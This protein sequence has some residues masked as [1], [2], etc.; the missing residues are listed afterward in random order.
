MAR[1]K[2]ILTEARQ[3]EVTLR[4]NARV[5]SRVIWS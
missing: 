3:I 1:S 5:G 2:S 4:A